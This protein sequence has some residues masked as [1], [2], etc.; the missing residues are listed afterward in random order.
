MAGKKPGV[1]EGKNLGNRGQFTGIRQTENT[2]IAYM[3]KN[4][5]K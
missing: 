3:I 1:F 2:K 4:K 5:M